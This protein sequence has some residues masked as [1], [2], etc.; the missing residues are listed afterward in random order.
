MAFPGPPSGY[1]GSPP[2]LGP[3]APAL[4]Q[5]PQCAVREIGNRDIE[6]S[7]QVAEQ[8]NS[9]GQH[10]A[11]SL[12]FCPENVAPIWPAYARRTGLR[13]WSPSMVPLP[14]IAARRINNVRA[15]VIPLLADERH[16]LKLFVAA[17]SDDDPP[18]THVW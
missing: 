14:E 10:L 13:S 5:L 11:S 9:K 2:A 15:D 16:G 7:S 6:T 12:A 4:A 18:P 8:F 17:I 3:V 1:A